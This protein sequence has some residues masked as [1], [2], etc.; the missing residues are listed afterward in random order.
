MKL[1]PFILSTL[2]I[3]AILWLTLAPHPLPDDDIPAFPGADKL[4]HACMF[5]GLYFLLYIDLE[6]LQ[7]HKKLPSGHPRRWDFAAGVFAVALGGA[8]ELLQEAM[9]LGRGCEPLDFAADT[10]GVVVSA[11]LSPVV[12]PLFL[13]GKKK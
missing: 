8:I 4:A 12:A 6:L 2:C 13:R 1:K 3:A 5:G 9:G 7:R 11:F 10:A